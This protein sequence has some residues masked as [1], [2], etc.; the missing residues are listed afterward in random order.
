MC[1]HARARVHT[2]PLYTPRA[3]VNRD[4]CVFRFPHPPTSTCSLRAPPFHSPHHGLPDYSPKN[5]LDPQLSGKASPQTCS[6]FPHKNKP[7]ITDVRM[8]VILE[9][10]AGWV[11]PQ[12]RLLHWICSV[13]TCLVVT[14]V[15]P[16]V[17][18][19]C[20]VHLR[21]VSIM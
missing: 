8:T 3:P 19:R 1:A 18:T 20:A 5:L 10:A 2:C 21:T 7:V 11:G 6:P 13:L 14:Q 9:G 4:Y 12:S 15:Y 17:K 16:H